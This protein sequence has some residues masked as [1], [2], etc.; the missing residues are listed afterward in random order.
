MQELLPIPEHMSLSPVHVYPQFFVIVF[1]VVRFYYPFFVLKR[2][3]LTI[4]L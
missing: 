2:F 4:I 3:D 1:A